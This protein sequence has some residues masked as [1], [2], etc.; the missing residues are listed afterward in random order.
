MFTSFTAVDDSWERNCTLWDAWRR[1]KQYWAATVDQ[2]QGKRQ[3]E[4]IPLEISYKMSM[5]IQTLSQASYTYIASEFV[6]SWFVLEYVSL[7]KTPTWHKPKWLC[8]LLLLLDLLICQEQNWI[9]TFQLNCTG[10]VVSRVW[11]SSVYSNE[12]FYCMHKVPIVC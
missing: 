12:S 6:A 1:W 4:M 11:W 10:N 8:E 7:T 5:Y 3:G 2:P 9:T